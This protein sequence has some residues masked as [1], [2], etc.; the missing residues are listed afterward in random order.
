MK[1]KVNEDASAGSTGAGSIASVPSNGLN[2]PLS[3]PLPCS[4]IF[5]K[6]EFNNKKG[7]E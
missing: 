3:R 1:K 2:Y 4:H 5:K 7:K 6:V